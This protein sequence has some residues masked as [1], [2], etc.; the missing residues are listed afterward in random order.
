MIRIKRQTEN[1]PERIALCRGGCGKPLTRSA[2]AGDVC[3]KCVK[4]SKR[5]GK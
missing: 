5:Q 1:L 3:P 2:K 4:K